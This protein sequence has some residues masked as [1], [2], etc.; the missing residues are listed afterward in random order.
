MN[1][2]IKKSLKIVAL[3][4]TSLVIATASAAS[5]SEL[6]ME[7]TNITIGSAGVL[8]TAGDDTSEVTGGDGIASPYTTVTFDNMTGIQPGETRIYSEAVNITNNAGV[9]KNVEISL[10]GDITGPFS[11]NFEYIY[12]SMIDTDNAT[13]GTQIQIVATGS[14]VTSTGSVSM[15]NGEVWAVSWVIKAQI[16]ATEAEAISLT[17]KVTVT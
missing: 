7:G 16:D 10:D 14:N 5:Y 2:K 15:S 1:V 9:S 8:F 3:L 12:V 17:L 13:K 4:V 11:D 6:F